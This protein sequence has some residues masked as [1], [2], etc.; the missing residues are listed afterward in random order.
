MEDVNN[1]ME[2]CGQ[3]ETT[4]DLKN[5]KLVN[6]RM[7]LIDEEVGELK[8]ALKNK[9]RIEVIDAL[10][11]ILFVVYGAGVAFDIDLD[12]AFDIVYESNMSKF[13]ST[14]EE[15]QETVEYYLKNKKQL[16]YDSPAYRKHGYIWVVYNKSTG[17]ILKSINYTPAKFDGM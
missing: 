9:D 14:E 2:A 17:K 4:R 7:S 8:E 10:A 5:D 16:G 15:A 6:F 3:T 1:F 11:D 13:C 12:K